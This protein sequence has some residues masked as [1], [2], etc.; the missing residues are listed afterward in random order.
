M[1]N[2]Q[3][4]ALVAYLSFWQDIGAGTR[5]EEAIDDIQISMSK[6]DVIHELF[7]AGWNY[8]DD[9]KRIKYDD[10]DED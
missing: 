4:R 7:K 1:T 10:G 5:I 8:D 6:Q 9:T 2:G 3:Y